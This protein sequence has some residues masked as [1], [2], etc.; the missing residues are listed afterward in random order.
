[1]R[2]KKKQALHVEREHRGDKRDAA[3]LDHVVSDKR[4][5]VLA[6]GLRVLRIAGR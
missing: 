4:A 5:R 1:M 2:K 6:N 3:R